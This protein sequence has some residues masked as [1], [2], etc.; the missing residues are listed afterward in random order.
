MASKHAPASADAKLIDSLPT[1]VITAF[2]S[3]IYV[4][5]YVPLNA[6]LFINNDWINAEQLRQFLK[7]VPDPD[8]SSHDAGQE[9]SD[10][11]N[12]Y[13][14]SIPRPAETGESSSVSGL[15]PP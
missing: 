4:P 14:V 2:R 1:G 13:L 10:M 12:Q 8:H 3:S 5:T 15:P 9:M 6:H 7:R 11:V